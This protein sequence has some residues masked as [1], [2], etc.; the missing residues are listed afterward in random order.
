MNVDSSYH[1]AFIVFVEIISAIILFSA[2]VHAAVFTGQLAMA[3]WDLL[4]RP[5][6]RRSNL[7]WQRFS[8]SAPPV[9]IIVP[10]YN[11]SL[12]IVQTVRSLMALEYPSYEIIIVNDGSTDDTLAQLNREFG[13]K[14]ASRPHELALNHE[15]I[16]AV[17]R[18]TTVDKLLVVDKQNGGKGDAQNAGINLARSPLFCILDGD[19]ILEVDALLRVVQPF[20]EDPEKVVAVGGTIRVANNCVI[21]GGR[22]ET[23]K[24]PKK[25]LALFQVVEYLRSFLMARLAWSRI[26][27]LMIISGAFGLFRRD[28][29]IEVGGYQSGSL[30]EDLDIVIKIHRHMAEKKRQY[31]ITF[32]ADPVCWTEAPEDIASLARQRERWQRGAIECFLRHRHMLFNSKYRRIGLLGMS[33]ILVVDMIGPVLEVLGYF[34]IPTF[35]LLGVL[36]TDF[37][38][39]WL[40]FIFVFGIFISVCSLLLEELGLRRFEKPSDILILTL[41]AIFENFG[42]RQ[43]N[44]FWRLKGLY[45]YVRGDR[46]WGKMRRTGFS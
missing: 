10:A 43:I 1:E 15:P 39:A 9:S 36:N 18:A 29:A 32:L 31:R 3:G 26:D 41:A 22:V 4:H 2:L 17:Y 12:G 42:Y 13:L 7:L 11:E 45:Q 30:A 14:P 33:H 46:S 35:W 20:I 37:F 24:L 5:K 25:L 16:R 21:D 23:I 19:S 34:L 27:T 38:L 6:I 8:E 28:V 44:N 40:A